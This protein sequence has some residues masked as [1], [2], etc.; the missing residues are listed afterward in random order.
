M[1][2][3]IGQLERVEALRD[4]IARLP[5]KQR[6]MIKARYEATDPEEL[7][8]VAEKQKKK[9]NAV[10]KQLERTRSALKKC[11]NENGRFPWKVMSRN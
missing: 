4:C 5:E 6:E 3:Q 1:C 11:G 10:Y 9:M 7:A 8:R 2:G